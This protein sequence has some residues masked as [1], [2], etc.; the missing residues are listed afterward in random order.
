[1]IVT[2]LVSPLVAAPDLK[3]LLEQY[4][5]DCHDDD[6]K[7]GGLNLDAI[8]SESPEAHPE[9]W[10]KVILRLNSRQMPPP[11]EKARPTE[12]EYNQSATELAAWFDQLAKEK[13][14]PGRTDSIR[15]LTRF[16]YRNSIRDLLALDLD[17]TELLPK[18]ES[19]QGFDNITL[20]TLSPTLLNRYVQAA[21]KISRLAVGIA[22][23]TPAGR[24]IRL[25][26]DLSQEN[27]VEGL[28]PGTRGGTQIEHPFPV[29]GEYEIEI[30]LTRDRNEEVEGLEDSNDLD[31]LLNDIPLKRFTVKPFR[32]RKKSQ[33][34]DADLKARFQ[35]P[36]GPASLA[37]TFVEKP[38]SLVETKRLPY[39]TNFNMHRHPRRS[40][41][42]Y[43]IS[44]TGPYQTSTTTEEA[45]SRK[46]IFHRLP[47]DQADEEPCA[48]E[49]F[50]RLIQRAYRRLATDED[51]LNPLAFFRE[52]RKSGDFYAAVEAGLSSILA[53][54][55]FFLRIEKD[56]AGV[57][58]DTTYP[59][60]NYALASRL[61]YFLWSSLPDD[62]LLNLA[63][64]GKL[65]Q[66]D[67][68]EGQARRLLADSRSSAFVTNFTGQWLHLRNLNSFHPDLR[69]F[70]DFDDNLRQALRRET[71]LFFQSILQEGRSALDLLR[72]D[73]TFLNERLAKHYEIPGIRGSQFRR[74]TLTP[75][76]HRG[77][78][79]R[80][81]SILAVTSYAN[82][83]SPVIRGNWILGNIL[84][85]PTPPPPPDVPSLDEN[86]VSA[87]L[88]MR[89]RLAAHRA[90]R[91]CAVCHD[92]MDPVGF[93]ME[94]FDATGRW[95]D[96]DE[97]RI[98]NAYGGLP[99]GQVLIGPD[100]LEAGLL[101]RPELFVRAIAEKML[102]YSLGRGSSPH[103]QPAI[104]TIVRNAEKNHY[105]LT[106]IIIGIVR[107]VPF[108]HR[109]TQP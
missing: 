63:K 69:L 53:S 74:V 39:D 15:R 58:P 107:S 45:P 27:H 8:L 97:E 41:A 78:L 23:P 71:E 56:P 84:G 64:D 28:P 61:S 30:R 109:K 52:A 86:I 17:V 89:E 54:P 47:A 33:Q 51:L 98:V 11:S 48:R 34:P 85:T 40:P 35:A 87:K 106:D 5:I 42:I 108:T 20:G 19:S 99:D 66:P 102:I 80:Q 93:A 76:T 82:R 81:G 16:E 96:L 12:E 36:S 88:P 55:R 105:Q 103:D 25:P 21:Q 3:P 57:V 22:P 46:L 2:S 77:G 37:V 44:I 43:Q 32:G 29:A 1:M 73:H 104:R 72:A 24:I 101:A 79:L 14:N 31:V 38:Q 68:L 4:C 13:P 95:R 75:E 62:E 92:L 7:R 50:S 90:D 49:I 65:T 67:I 10:E 60:D 18:D 100:Q 26:A 9:I 83:T 91:S 94:N 59:I 6:I 70:P